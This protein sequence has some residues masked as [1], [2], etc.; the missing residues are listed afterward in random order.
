MPSG[1][2]ADTTNPGATVSDRLMMPAVDGDVA[3]P[4]GGDALEQSGETGAGHE[5]DVVGACLLH[6]RRFRA[7]VGERLRQARRDVLHERAAGDDVEELDA[8]ADGEEREI[9]IERESGQAD[10][11]LVTIRVDVDRAVPLG[12]AVSRRDRRRRHRSAAR[13]RTRSSAS[14]NASRSGLRTSGSPPARSSDFR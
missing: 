6:A 14:G 13:H 1:A 10:L 7:A 5:R 3:V 11:V 4:P 9:A 2:V 8:A 12:F